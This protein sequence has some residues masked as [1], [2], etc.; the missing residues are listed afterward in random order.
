MKY[1]IIFMACFA[2]AGCGPDKNT[3][4]NRLVSPEQDRADLQRAHETGAIS[5]EEY[6]KLSTHY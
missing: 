2:L 4:T 1:L 5:D 6:R 3:I